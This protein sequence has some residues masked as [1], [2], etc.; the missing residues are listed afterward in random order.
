MKYTLLIS[1]NSNYMI[2][3]PCLGNSVPP[4]ALVMY[5]W[6]E[7]FLSCGFNIEMLPVD[8]LHIFVYL[9]NFLYLLICENLGF[10]VGFTWGL[11]HIG[12]KYACW[13]SSWHNKTHSVR[14]WIF[15]LFSLMIKSLCHISMYNSVHWQNSV[16]NKENS[17]F[18]L[19]FSFH[20][21]PK[22]DLGNFTCLENV[23]EVSFYFISM[24]RCLH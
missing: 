10:C 6:L 21:R 19:N 13:P 16:A 24:L 18:V 5:W 20:D 22:A 14:I 2:Q 15:R 1:E 9:S 17:V 8:W 12:N 23:L 11:I 7:S 4:A 3:M